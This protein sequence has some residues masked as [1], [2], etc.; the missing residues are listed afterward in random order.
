[1]QYCQGSKK[2]ESFS[3]GSD[4]TGQCFTED[5]S[6]LDSAGVLRQGVCNM[7]CQGFSVIVE[8]L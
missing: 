6:G 7:F 1:M 3:P 4:F 5:L 8:K 2:S